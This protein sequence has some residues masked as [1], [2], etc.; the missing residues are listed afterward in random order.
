MSGSKDRRR[1]INTAQTKMRVLNI[2]LDQATDTISGFDRFQIKEV[3]DLGAGNHTIVFERPFERDC[4]ATG[5]VSFTAD[6]TVQV[7][8][9]AYDRITVQCATAGAPADINFSL[10]IMGSDSRFDY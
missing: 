10:Q 5:A 8:A 3:L 9:V 6:S 7:T 4:M 1:G 2:R